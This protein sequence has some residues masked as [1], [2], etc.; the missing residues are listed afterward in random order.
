MDFDYVIGVYLKFDYITPSTTTI[1][2]DY[3]T[4]IFDHST[5]NSIILDSILLIMQKIE[6]YIILHFDYVIGDSITL[7]IQDLDYII[8][9]RLD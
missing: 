9:I 4:I 5:I 6:D 1:K 3:T 8:Y 2:L 7:F